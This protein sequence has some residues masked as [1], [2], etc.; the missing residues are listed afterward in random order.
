[1]SLL[2]YSPN[3]ATWIAEQDRQMV[4]FAI[5]EWS[6]EETGTEGYIQTIEVI[7]S[8][9]G[10]GIGGELLA[11]VEDAAK[12]AGCKFIWLHVDAANQGAIRLYEAC[13]YVFEGRAENYYERRRAALIYCR[14]LES[15]STD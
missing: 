9:R 3:A 6:K 1:M 12:G 4:G 2:T 5:V 7:P 8:E 14:T 10:H 13:G 15:I 11:R